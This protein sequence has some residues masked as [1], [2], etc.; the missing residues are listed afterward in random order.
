MARGADLVLDAD[1]GQAVGLEQ[2]RQDL[3][4]AALVHVR[5][6]LVQEDDALL[7]DQHAG[8]RQLLLFAAG[9]VA[10][11]VLER[12]VKVVRCKEGLHSQRA[13]HRLDAPFKFRAIESNV[14][15]EGIVKE[16]RI[17]KDDAELIIKRGP[18]PPDVRSSRQILSQLLRTDGLTVISIEH[19]VSPEILPLY[20]TILELKDKRLVERA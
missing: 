6:G 2:L 9:K 14:L 3:L 18:Q 8:E 11:R 15:E 10:L 20:D 7:L 5:G 13:H 12:L 16:E 1:D 17:L 19:K 4:A